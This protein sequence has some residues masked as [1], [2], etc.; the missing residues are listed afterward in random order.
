MELLAP[1]ARPLRIGVRDRSGLP[2]VLSVRSAVFDRVSFSTVALTG[3]S[4]SRAR[5]SAAVSIWSDTSLCYTTVEHA[6]TVHERRSRRLI[7]GHK[8]N[9]VRVF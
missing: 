7:T 9:T 3:Q 4:Y 5:S 1:A 6:T 2:D 8:N